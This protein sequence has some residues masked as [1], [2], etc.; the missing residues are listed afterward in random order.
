MNIIVC[1]KQV[2]DPEGPPAAFQLD[3]EQNKVVPSGIPPVLSSYDE[4]ALE[5]A[6]QFREAFAENAKITVLSV[7]KN[8]S[9]NV[10]IKAVAAGADEVILVKD[11]LFDDMDSFQTA[12]A[13]AG[14]I[15]KI[16]NFDLI[17]CGIEAA[18]ANNGQVGIGVAELLGIPGM[19][20]VHKI[21]LSDGRLRMERVAPD[22]K[23]VFESEM[24]FL[25]T[26]GG[27]Q[28]P[29]RNISIPAIVKARKKTVPVWSG[30]DVDFSQTKSLRL[31][32][33][34]K[35]VS[36]RHCEMIDGETQ[37]AM[38]QNL[39]HKLIESNII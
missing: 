39:A 7:G 26:I 25:A 20:M 28:Y 22:G 21:E 19:T 13:L 3:Q 38:G 24:P 17:L 2:P 5:A 14:A 11:D 35:R 16:G 4:N 34:T 1:M 31:L 29:F 12:H 37:E 36:S 32:S 18:D 8:P 15:R 10:F 23:G 33:L 6:L 30:D 27:E 9:K